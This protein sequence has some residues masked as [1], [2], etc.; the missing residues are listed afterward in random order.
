MRD[1]N[2]DIWKTPTPEGVN[3]LSCKAL[4]A[5]LMLIM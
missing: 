5:L 4:D 2:L 3:Q 1:L